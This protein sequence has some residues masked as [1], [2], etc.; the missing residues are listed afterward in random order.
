MVRRVC[1][2]LWL[3]SCL[4]LPGCGQGSDL[5]LVPVSGQVKFAGGPCPLPGTITFM[6]RSGSGGRG[7]PSRPGAATFSTDGQFKVTSFHE[8]D[9]LLP[10]IYGVSIACRDSKYVPGM[11]N[12]SDLDH[13]PQDY[14]PEELVVKEGSGPIVV[15]YDVPKKK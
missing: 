6:P 4:M 15:N 13:V 10:G 5:P 3:V 9:G 2:F 11:P 8:G 7:M 14:R 12:A 1:V